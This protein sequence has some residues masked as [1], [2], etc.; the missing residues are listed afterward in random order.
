[1]T[2][3]IPA[4]F[5]KV[6]IPNA[7]TGSAIFAGYMSMMSTFQGEYTLAAWL[8]LAACVLDML[9]GRVARLMKASSEF[10][11]Q[12]DSLADVVNYGVA[13]SLLFHRL[14]FQ[15]ADFIGMAISFLPV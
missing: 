15:N 12:F 4:K 9:D 2:K 14:F 13:P 7:I 6:L 3:G 8:I 11:V 5:P 10:G 1:M